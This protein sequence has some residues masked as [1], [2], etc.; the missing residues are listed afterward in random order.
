[1]TR[2]PP[3]LAVAAG[4]VVAQYMIGPARR[5]TRSSRIAAA[6]VAVGAAALLVR[7][8]VAFRQAGTTVDPREQAASDT[9]VTTGANAISRN[10]MYVGMA[11]LLTARAIARR[12][13]PALLPVVAFVA[14]IDRV[15]IPAEEHHLQQRFGNEYEHYTARVPRWL[16]PLP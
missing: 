3:P 5:P 11:G 2:R 14:W 15:Q 4:A 9:L 8:I 7:P 1:M 6:A 13:M 12:S 10:P 16:R